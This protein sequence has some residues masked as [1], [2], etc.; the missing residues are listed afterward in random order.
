MLV[1][2]SELTPPVAVI[3]NEKAFQKQDAVFV[4]AKRVGKKAQKVSCRRMMWS[5]CVLSLTRCT[6]RC[7]LAAG[8]PILPIHRPWLQ[9]PQDRH[10][11]YLRRQEVPLHR[12][13][14]HPRTH[15]EG[16]G[17]VQQD[18]ENHRHPSRLPAVHP[19]VQK[20]RNIVVSLLDVCQ[21]LMGVLSVLCRFE[22]RHKRISVHCSPCFLN[23]SEGDI[24]TVGQCRPLAK[25]VKFN[26]IDHA[27]SA[28]KVSLPVVDRSCR[29]LTPP[30]LV[31]CSPST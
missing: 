25:T 31:C 15:P 20:V 11:R 30:L 27:P 29:A 24:V 26:V 21:L 10:H 28:N 8:K 1:S 4:A 7:C 5:C 6:V 2:E 17:R 13:R 12:Q 16:H 19:Q 14:V 18:E 22:K 3:Q 23:V 9:D